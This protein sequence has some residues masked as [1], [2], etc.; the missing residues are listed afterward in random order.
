[1]HVGAAND[2]TTLDANSLPSII[3]EVKARG[4][5]LVLISDYVT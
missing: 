4:Y 2:G 3:R 1:M 5:R